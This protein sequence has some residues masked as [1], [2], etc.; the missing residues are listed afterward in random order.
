MKRV[1]TILVAAIG[2]IGLI[3]GPAAAADL[4]DYSTPVVHS[5]VWNGLEVGV[6][7]GYAWRRHKLSI[8][9]QE[10]VPGEPAYCRDDA[11]MGDGKC[12]TTIVDTPAVEESCTSGTP[13]DGECWQVIVDKAASCGKGPYQAYEG[14]CYHE[15][16]FDE[17]N[18]PYPNATT[19]PDKYKPAA[20]HEEVDPNGEY[21][22]PV[23]AVTHQEEAP[24]SYVPA[25]DATTIIHNTLLNLD[26]DGFFGGGHIGVNWQPEGTRVLTGIYGDFN[27]ADDSVEKDGLKITDGNSYLIAAKLGLLL[28]HDFTAYV[29]GG[30]GWQDV[31]YTPAHDDAIDHTF[32]H[33]VI[34]AGA[35]KLLTKNLGLGIEAQYW[36]PAEDT[37]HDGT[38]SGG[39][40]VKDERSDTRVLGRLN[41]H[42]GTTN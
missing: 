25:V 32:G 6:H 18:I 16:A 21:S 9:E 42:I 23:A 17:D 39:A 22:E 27:F 11:T 31:T 34:G 10:E 30:Y 13:R 29:M 40:L 12:Y 8:T 19:F 15:S 33:W 36:T 41:W 20:T 37:I 26:P 4:G 14:T 5:N 2:L 1:V 28:S 3:A 38:A 7:A 24:L 35:E